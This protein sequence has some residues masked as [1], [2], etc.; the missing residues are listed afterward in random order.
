MSGSLFSKEGSKT[1]N[2]N[3]DGFIDFRI[4]IKLLILELKLLVYPHLPEM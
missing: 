3:E 1:E 4:L 2:Q